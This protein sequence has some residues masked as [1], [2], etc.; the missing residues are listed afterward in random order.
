M[1]VFTVLC[2]LL[3]LGSCGQSATA[4]TASLDADFVLAPGQSAAIEST[5][6]TV[7]FQKVVQDSRCPTNVQCV[8][9]GEAIV[10]ITVKSSSGTKDYDLDSD[11]REPVHHDDLTIALVKVTPYP[12]TNRPIAAEDY[13]ATFRVTK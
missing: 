6:T 1:P 7:Q 5:G 13:R 10:R 12:A 4:P 9:A 3:V 11:K 8:R 2:C